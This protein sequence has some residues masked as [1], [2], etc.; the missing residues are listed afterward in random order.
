[1][2]YRLQKLPNFDKPLPTSDPQ[3]NMSVT[4]WHR[5]PEEREEFPQ[6]L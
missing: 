2:R 1:M 4:G 5:N 6:R 3:M